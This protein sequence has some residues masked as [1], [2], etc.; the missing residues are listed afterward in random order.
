I[1]KNFVVTNDTALLKEL[2]T[3][4]KSLVNE[5]STKPT[6]LTRWK[7][8]HYLINYLNQNWEVKIYITEGDWYASQDLQRLKYNN[9]GTLANCDIPCVWKE[10]RLRYWVPSEELKTADAL[11]CVNRPN[12]PIRKGWEGQKFINYNLEPVQ[13]DFGRFDI[14]VTFEEFSDVPTSYIRMDHNEW[15]R[16][17][18]FNVTSLSPNSTFISFIASHWTEF[19]ETWIPTLQAHVPVASFGKVYPNTPWD[20]ECIN[21][22]WF[23]MKNC[24]ISKYP[25]YLAIENSQVQDYSTEKL[26]D[27]FKLGVVPVIW[28]APNTRSYL[29]HPKSAIFIDDFPN[30]EELANYLKYLVGN[31]TA[32]LE[33]HQWRTMKTWPEEFEKKAY[34]SMWNMECN[35]CKEVARLRIV[36]GLTDEM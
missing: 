25:F 9:D 4:I 26:W 20:S 29:P 17:K 3:T 30:V 1:K 23:E 16:K 7:R 32:Y 22:E 11:F 8:W 31:E 14:L 36:K 35:V 12:L 19:R 10:K 34:M 24:I 33:Y 13:H 28:G 5:L 6:S 18:P 27:T 21:F 15:R 2:N